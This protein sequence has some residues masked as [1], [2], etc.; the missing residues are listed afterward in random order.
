MQPVPESR[1]GFSYAPAHR[2]DA[3]SPGAPVADLAV[4]V[5]AVPLPIP[6]PG[7]GHT[8]VPGTNIQR[9]QVL[10]IRTRDPVSGTAHARYRTCSGVR[11]CTCAH[12]TRCQVLHKV[13]HMQ[14]CQVPWCQVPYKYSHIQLPL[15]K[16]LD[17]ETMNLQVSL[18]V[19]M[20][21]I[22]RF[23]TCRL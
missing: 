5:P 19:V 9:C 6:V 8:T 11:Y 2:S 15:R 3:V 17:H 10:H 20:Q 4:P 1:A 14:W 12:E 16:L 21:T 13:L 18:P 23:K 7:T 22:D